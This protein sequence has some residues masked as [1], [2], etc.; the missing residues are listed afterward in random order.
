MTQHDTER[1]WAMLEG[2]DR[3]G[4]AASE[5]LARLEV[6]LDSGLDGLQRRLNELAAGPGKNP[7]CVAHE[8][9]LGF[10]EDALRTLCARLWWLASALGGGFIMLGLKTLWE[11]VRA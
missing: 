5:Q 8:A 3:R 10:V 9:R 6:R 2:Q 1:L 7:S 11:V 4:R